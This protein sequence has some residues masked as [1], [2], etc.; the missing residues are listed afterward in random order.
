MRTCYMCGQTKP[1]P[2][3]AFTDMAKGTRQYHCRKCQATYRRAHYLANRD[4]Y[5]RREVARINAYRVRTAH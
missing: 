4:E 3:F 1:E 5:I 2:D